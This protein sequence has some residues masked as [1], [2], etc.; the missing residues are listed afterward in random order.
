[1]NIQTKDERQPLLRVSASHTVDMYS[2][3]L[4]VS[5]FAPLRHRGQWC[6]KKNLTFERL[7]EIY[8]GSISYFTTR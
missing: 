8:S 7:N 3:E 1:M 2:K 4:I 5:P 6:E